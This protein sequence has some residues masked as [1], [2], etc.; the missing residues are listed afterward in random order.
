MEFEDLSNK[1]IGLAIE[2]H[3]NLGPGLLEN[4]YKECLAYELSNAGLKYEKEKPVSVN[5]KNTVIP[6]GYRIDILVENKI[7]IELK[8]VEK[9]HPVFEAQILTYMRLSNIKVG[10]LLNFYEKRLSDGLK[11]YVV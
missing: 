1:I 3:K 4:T 7:L 10:L 9:I 11:R 2:V 5:Y 8:S 6:V